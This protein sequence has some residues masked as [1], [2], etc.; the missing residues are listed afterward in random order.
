MNHTKKLFAL[1]SFFIICFCS[2]LF[3]TGAGVQIGGNPG[4]YIN[5]NSVK[6]DYFSGTLTGTLR[7]SRIPMSVGFGFEAG[8]SF[9]DFAYGLSGFADYYL[10]DVQLKNTWN[11]YSGLGIEGN[12]LTPDF[13]DWSASAGA[14]LFVGMNWLFYDNYLEF[15]AQQNIV[16]GWI[17]SLSQSDSKGAFILKLPL[18]AGIRFHF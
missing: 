8:K 4:L 15:Y 1:T 3:A 11:F 13:K 6:P 5:D 18:E 7:F 16:P 14:R 10:I 12:L 2:K 17:K 9:S